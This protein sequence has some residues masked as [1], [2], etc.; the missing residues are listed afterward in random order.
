LDGERR[1]AR[2][3]ALEGVHELGLEFYPGASLLDRPSAIDLVL[4]AP[5]PE[6]ADAC[7]RVPL[8]GPEPKLFWT[9]DTLMASGGALR[10]YLPV[11]ALRGLG[12]GWSY[13]LMLG[14]Y[15]G[16]VRAQ[17]EAGIGFANCESDCRDEAFGF[18]VVPLG[19]ALHWLVLDRDGVAVDLGLS[20]RFVYASVGDQ[21]SRSFWAH[22][23]TVSVRLAGTVENGLGILG[24]ARVGSTGAEI[25]ASDW[26]YPG[27][28]ADERAFVLGA[29]WSWDSTW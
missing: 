22:A 10:G 9:K 12:A 14:A 24:G 26:R 21:S 2:P 7:L 15:M 16:P 8:N 18:L 5:S 11:R 4:A 3:F 27:L 25:F 20:Y 23:P 29:A 6:G 17:L 28:D 13:D 1:W 19:P